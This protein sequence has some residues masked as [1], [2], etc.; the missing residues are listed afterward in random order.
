MSFVGIAPM[1][2]PEYIV[3]VALDTPSRDTGIYISGGVMA[4]PTV[5][6]VME[7]I[8]P[9]LGVERRL[10]GDRVIL[11]D[12]TGMAASEAEKKLKSLGLTAN[13]TGTGERV[14]AQLPE[15]GQTVA[16]GSQVL[17]YLEDTGEMPSVPVPDF[18][19]M[20]RREAS[21]AASDAGLT[22][23]ITGNGEI[24]PS[25]TVTAQNYEKDTLVPLGTTVTLTFTDTG[26]RD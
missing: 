11:E 20:N 14:L 22:I 9:Y 17:L 4:A 7:G 23:L 25:I 3:L 2:D 6:A 19:G 10:E 5:G 21:Q 13:V 18:T 24:A 12:Y 26:A 8:L 15:P 16:A 1:E